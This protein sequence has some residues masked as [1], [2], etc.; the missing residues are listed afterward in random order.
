MLELAI[1]RTKVLSFLNR[2]EENVTE[3]D[4]ISETA[5]VTIE[6][7]RRYIDSI[8]IIDAVPVVRCSE[9]RHWETDWEPGQYNPDI[10]RH[11]CAVT[12]L[13]TT[14]N[15]FCKEGNNK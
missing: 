15:W 1:S 7:V 6:C 9:C 13:F 4:L 11:F 5:K 2:L 10:P 12:D 8:P 14:G 3:D